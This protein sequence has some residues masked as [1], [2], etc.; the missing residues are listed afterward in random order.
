MKRI[1][2]L[3]FGLMLAGCRQSIGDGSEITSAGNIAGENDHIYEKDD[4]SEPN[5]EEV[6]SSGDKSAVKSSDVNVISS[7]DSVEAIYDDAEK[8][9]SG[10]D[11][12][13]ETWVSESVEIRHDQTLADVY[14]DILLG[15]FTGEDYYCVFDLNHDDVYEMAATSENP[16]HNGKYKSIIA[17]M[18]SGDDSV[19]CM[20]FYTNHQIGFSQGYGQEDG[21]L[22]VRTGHENVH[23]YAFYI[24]DGS[25]HGSDYLILDEVLVSA[26]K[27]I[28]KDRYQQYVNQ[29]RGEFRDLLMWRIE[30]GNLERDFTENEIIAY[31][32]NEGVDGYLRTLPV[33]S[34]LGIYD[35]FIE[36]IFSK[37]YEGIM[38]SYGDPLGKRVEC[39]LRKDGTE[40]GGVLQYVTGY[41]W[42]SG[43]KGFY[44]TEYETS[45]KHGATARTLEHTS[46]NGI[47]KDINLYDSTGKTDMLMGILDSFF[48]VY[49]DTYSL[50]DLQNMIDAPFYRNP[51]DDEYNVVFCFNGHMFYIAADLEQNMVKRDSKVIVFNDPCDTSSYDLLFDADGNIM[52]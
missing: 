10:E 24:Q 6:F 12:N 8:V 15:S 38:D 21:K 31:D 33:E 17:C 47:V 7:S 45:F 5:A 1:L 51:L 52:E 13:A 20:T 50:N 2:L 23:H 4:M 27:S 44:A 9:T 37:G 40:N 41:L 29:D 35:Y 11:V 25:I 32:V 26:D 48:N 16:E 28:D 14:K 39:V 34:S 36:D 30:D 42:C 49:E 18:D 46:I 19:K 43:G 22:L 3:M